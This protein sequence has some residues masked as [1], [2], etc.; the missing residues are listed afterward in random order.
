MTATPLSYSERRFKTL[1]S[2][3]AIRKLQSPYSTVDRFLRECKLFVL[4][5]TKR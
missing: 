2:R 5:I 1:F 4:E 3:F